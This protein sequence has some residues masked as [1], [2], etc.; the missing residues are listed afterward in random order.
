MA[1]LANM[2]VLELIFGH[3]KV[4]VPEKAARVDAVVQYRLTGE[5]GGDWYLTI[6]DGQCKVAQGLAPNPK[7]MLTASAHDFKDI[8]LGKMD[9][10]Q[11]FMQGKLKVTG[12]L[13]LAMRFMGFFKAS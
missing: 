13:N 11:A 4:F 1:D 10:M 12:D 9:G 5:E 6:K 8:L 3:E 2:S 7:M